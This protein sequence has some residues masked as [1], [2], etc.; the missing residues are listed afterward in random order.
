[1]VTEANGDYHL[2]IPP[3]IYRIDMSHRT[4]GRFTKDVPTT[5]PITEGQQTRLD[6]RINTGIR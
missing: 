3:G 5:V 4:G 1:M 6:I 2:R